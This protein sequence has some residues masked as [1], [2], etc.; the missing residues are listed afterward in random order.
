MASEERSYRR[1]LQSDL[2]SFRVTV[3][4]SDLM[5]SAE[6]PLPRVGERA[7]RAVRRELERYLERDPEF[8]GALRPHEP[9]ADAPA[10]ACEMAEAGRACGVGPMAAV[11]GAI[12]Q[13]VG[14]ALLDESREVIVENGGDVFLHIARPRVSAIFAGSSPLS[15]RVGV[16]VARVDEEV[17]LCTSSGT[18]GP[19]LSFGRADAAIVL[20]RSAALADAAATALG[21]RVQDAGDIERSLEDMKGVAGILGL[22]VIAG[23]H[24]GAWGEVELVRVGEGEGRRS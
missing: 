5:V 4:E 6:R 22:A 20:A 13:R 21:N 3:G 9:L 12:A 16:R 2:R 14:E 1:W 7:L 24:L 18:V 17:G 10:I 19:S 11:A 23:E 15:G 8:G